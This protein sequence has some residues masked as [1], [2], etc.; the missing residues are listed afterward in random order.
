MAENQDKA[1]EIIEI[2]RKTGKIKKGV[3]EVTKSVERVS[4][5]FVA[6][7]EDVNPKEV[8]MHLEPLCNEK[9]IPIL[10]VPSREDLGAAA[11]LQV[12]TASVSVVV[13]GEAKDLI[14][15][16][17]KAPAKEAAPKETKKKVKEE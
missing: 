3:N 6:V 7:A 14:A 16:L 11:G 4:A 1:Y 5:K 10:K 8:I 2:A 15:S 9:Q 13:E 17:T 12:G